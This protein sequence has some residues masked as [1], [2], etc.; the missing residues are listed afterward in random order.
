LTAGCERLKK[1]GTTLDNR[2]T[3]PI[4]G[5]I[6]DLD[7]TLYDMSWY[8]KPLFFLR[9]FPRG[10]RLPRFLHIRE[11]FAGKDLGSRRGLIDALSAEVSRREGS[12][13]DEVRSW[14]EGPFYDAFVA[15]MPFF[16]FSRPGLAPLLTSLREKGIRLCVL[17]D[18]DRVK[19]RLVKLSLPPSLFDTFASS[20]AAGALKPNAGP[21]SAVAAEWGVEPGSILVVGDRA[22]TDGAAAEA[23]GMQFVL[24]ENGLRRRG[25]G[26]NWKECA[27]L[28]FGLKRVR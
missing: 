6:F 18:Y 9:L 21:F 1:A 19:E 20:E 24:V 11:T 13:F 22:D 14:I 15:I 3:P 8:M 27:A 23:A 7:G 28:L 26:L 12:G 4:R 5:I 10:T 2:V 25:T 17:S 16:R